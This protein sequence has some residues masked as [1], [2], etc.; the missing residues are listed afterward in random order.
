MTVSDWIGGLALAAFFALPFGMIANLFVSL[1]E[2]YRAGAAFE[3]II[4]QRD[5]R[6]TS[7]IAGIF[8][9]ICTAPFALLFRADRIDSESWEQYVKEHRCQVTD[10]RTRTEYRTSGYPP[11]SHSETVTEYLWRCEGGDEHWRR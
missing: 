8:I 6:R 2:P 4:T 3:S 11:M 7:Y 10:Q 1:T 9:L 5:V